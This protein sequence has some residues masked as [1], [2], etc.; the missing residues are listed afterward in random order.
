MVADLPFGSYEVSDEQAIA[1]AV[2]FVKEAGADAVKLER[3]DESAIS[4]ARAIVGAGIPV[5]GHVGLTPQSAT[6]LGGYR[7]QGRTAESAMRITRGALGLQ[8][9]GCF[10]I[11]FEAVPTAVTADI[12]PRMTVP[13]IGIGAGP[14]TDGQVL[15]FHDLLGIRDGA[16]AKFVRRYAD[17]QDAMNEGVTRYAEDVR[18][19]SFPGVE[20]GYGIDQPELARFRA[21]QNGLPG[22]AVTASPL[23]RPAQIG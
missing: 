17:L 1:T 21:L 15:V 10:C 13:V 2:R 8:D 6:S 12:M 3:G 19:G 14:A 7:A 20:H 18:N 9:A 22:G 4:R 5:V 23:I 11:V 16:G